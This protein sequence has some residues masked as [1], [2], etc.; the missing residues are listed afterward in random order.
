LP[1]GSV[2]GKLG[3]LPSPAMK[4]TAMCM[5]VVAAGAS[6]LGGCGSHD[7][8]NDANDGSAPDAP[9]PDGAILDSSD[10][11]LDSSDLAA[12]DGQQF[13]NPSLMLTPPSRRRIAAAHGVA[14]ATSAA[15]AVQCWGSQPGGA[16]GTYTALQGTFFNLTMGSDRLHDSSDP[17]CGI[18]SGGTVSCAYSDG[19]ASVELSSCVMPAAGI[20]D[21]DFDR[22][23]YG[24]LALVDASGRA[25]LTYPRL[26]LGSSLPV[27]TAMKKVRVADH[28]ACAIDTRGAAVCWE[29]DLADDGGPGPVESA[30]TDAYVDIAVTPTTACAVTS[31]G[32]V[33]CWNSQGVENT[34]PYEFARTVSNLPKPVVQLA[35][36]DFGGNL[37]ALLADGTVHCAVDFDLGEEVEIMP[38]L[39][40]VE[41]AVGDG[42]V[43]GIEK[44]DSVVCVP[45]GC[46]D[47]TAS[48]TPP[49]GFKA[50]ATN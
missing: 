37:C 18:A 46:S 32:L 10:G 23:H 6:L 49:A 30:P 15:S 48:I 20:T 4:N 50:I 21:I 47:C 13:E 40:V 33:R 35:T 43:C 8:S 39:H 29:I 31:K 25:S 11:T 5:V 19:T 42:F 17:V 26:C 12:A 14:C 24:E 41:I 9:V 27:D 7:N 1:D 44:D 22:W 38:G 3:E 28:H 36:D 34:V 2:H 45:W 16:I